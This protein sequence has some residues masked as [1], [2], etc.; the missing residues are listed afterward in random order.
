MKI[1]LL[2][3]YYTM[4]TVNLRRQKELDADPKANKEI[5]IFIQKEF[6]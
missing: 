6:E 4:I 2:D 1:I 3:V 5:E